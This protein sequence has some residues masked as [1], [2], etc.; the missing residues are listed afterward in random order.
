MTQ[1]S[2]NDTYIDDGLEDTPVD[3][4]IARMERSFPA[5]TPP[6][7]RAHELQVLSPDGELFTIESVRGLPIAAPEMV[8][9]LGRFVDPL[10]PAAMRGEAI[11]VIGWHRLTGE[12]VRGRALATSRAGRRW[13]AVRRV[14]LSGS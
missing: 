8:D 10:D 7:Q 5:P 2:S 4:V 14:L 11:L 6:G 1:T 12:T 9:P 3:D 13:S